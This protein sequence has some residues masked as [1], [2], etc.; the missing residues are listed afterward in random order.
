MNIFPIKTNKDYKSA[1]ARIESL[2][3]AKRGTREMDELEILSV[4]VEKYEDENF[5]ISPPDP[6]EAIKF[7]M[8]QLGL[9]KAELA[10]FLGGR[11]RA[12]EVLQRKRGLTVKMLKSLHKK[13]KIP[14]ESLLA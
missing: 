8:E 14:A 9:K 6:I 1:L 7:R 5:P 10:I 3:D 11:N 2:T 4:L 13:L 12:T